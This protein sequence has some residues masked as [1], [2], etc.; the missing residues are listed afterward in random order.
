MTPCSSVEANRRFGGT[1]RLHIQGWRV[2]HAKNPT[3]SRHGVIYHKKEHFVTTAVRTSYHKLRS[4]V[5]SVRKLDL[6]MLF[7]LI[8]DFRQLTDWLYVHVPIIRQCFLI[9]QMS[10]LFSI[11]ASLRPTQSGS[12]S[13]CILNIGIRRWVVNFINWSLYPLGN[14][15]SHPRE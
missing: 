12:I 15:H 2:S 7:R 9:T 6:W 4:S 10:C 13:P 3:R 14:S 8:S 5:F 1:S 11:T